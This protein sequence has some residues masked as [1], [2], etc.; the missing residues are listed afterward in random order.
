MGRV[1]PRGWATARGL[2]PSTVSKARREGRLPVGPDGLVDP[3]EADRAFAARPHIAGN[4]HA[5]PAAGA[6]DAYQQARAAREITRA[7]REQL[8]LERARDGAIPRP[9]VEVWLEGIARA[10]AAGLRL[11][12]T[13]C[14]ASLTM[15]DFETVRELLR[16]EAEN[17][18]HDVQ[19]L[20]D[21]FL[22]QSEPRHGR[23]K[24]RG[25]EGADE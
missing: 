5:G 1:T 23:R 25:R 12:P 13:R 14:A 9:T 8:E 16:Q 20:V 3:A 6:L 18:V 11:L 10:V 22:G 4:G 2:A 24:R 17:G 21:A 7:A 19:R 15:K